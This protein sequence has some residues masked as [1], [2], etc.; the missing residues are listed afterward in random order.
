MQESSPSRALS[1]G[2]LHSRRQGDP[3]ENEA[4]RVSLWLCSP[5]TQDKT[6][7]PVH[8][9]PH[10]S[11]ATTAKSRA[12]KTSGNYSCSISLCDNPWGQQTPPLLASPLFLCRHL[13]THF[14]RH[15]RST[16]TC[17][18]HIPT[19]QCP[20][21]CLQGPR[22]EISLQTHQTGNKSVFLFTQIGQ[23]WEDAAWG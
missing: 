22:T 9:L 6:R 23:T 21:T 2:F 19:Q 5:A 1:L 7:S 20:T 4:R 13:V 10:H 12:K 14:S 11:S 16:T 8:P 17:I 18:H 15:Q 3:L